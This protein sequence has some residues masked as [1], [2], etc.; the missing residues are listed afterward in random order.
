MRT[1]FAAALALAVSPIA[2]SPAFAADFDKVYV[3]PVAAELDLN[4]TPFRNGGDRAISEDDIAD[5]ADDFRDAIVN[6]LDDNF[7]IVDEPGPGVLSVEAKL[8]YLQSTKP[9][10]QDLSDEPSLDFTRSVYVGGAD[11]EATLTL[12]G[13]IIAELGDDYRGT[14]GDGRNRI[15]VWA[16]AD[17]AF[18]KFARQIE[19]AVE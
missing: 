13:D 14:F 4:V 9:T 15:A 12:D 8:T 18:R 19:K 7:A 1:L 5:K 2:V 10:M 6:A 17:R 11:Y 16:D 3:A